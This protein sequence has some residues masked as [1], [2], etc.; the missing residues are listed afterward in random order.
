MIQEGLK[1]GLLCVSEAGAWTAKYLG[2][3]LVGELTLDWNMVLPRFKKKKKK[4][5]I[6]F[7]NVLLMFEELWV[8]NNGLKHWNLLE[9]GFASISL[10]TPQP[11]MTNDELKFSRWV[12]CQQFVSF[13]NSSSRRFCSSV[14]AVNWVKDEAW[15]LSPFHLGARNG[16]CVWWL[17][18]TA[19]EVADAVS[20][21]SGLGRVFHPFLS[22]GV[23]FFKQDLSYLCLPSQVRVG[24]SM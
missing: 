6:P 14:W 2:W 13:L 19:V 18:F 9:I 7:A 11:W 21:L 17:S 3:N 1:V 15:T 24:H 4:P 10:I 12:D 22:S 23:S 8:K 16:H 20:D 5:V